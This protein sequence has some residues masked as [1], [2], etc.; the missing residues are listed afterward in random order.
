MT[1]APEQQAS[2]SRPTTSWWRLALLVALALLILGGVGVWVGVH[3]TQ[4][5]AAPLPA[6]APIV[7]AWLLDAEGAPFVPHVAIFHADGTF[8]IDNPEAGDP[9]S[10][11]SLGVGA[12]MLDP[13][14]VGV[15]LGTFEEIN[16]DRA[17]GHYVSRLL[18]TFT[19]TMQGANAFTGP[20]EA[21]YFA[22]D[23]TKQNAQPYPAI[24][25]GTR[26]QP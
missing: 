14:H 20:A 4:T 23:G 9:H 13:H 26:I 17:S 22:P 19:L 1:Q 7:G 16:A 5:Q 3:T 24:L 21:T 10:S 8:L 15:V 18:V 6:R 25:I 12:W 2:L 11:D